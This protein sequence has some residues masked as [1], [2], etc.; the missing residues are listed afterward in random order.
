LPQHGIA[1]ST[2]FQWRN[3]CAAWTH[4]PRLPALG[5]GRIPSPPEDGAFTNDDAFKNR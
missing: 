5:I 2:M 4:C 3:V 1:L